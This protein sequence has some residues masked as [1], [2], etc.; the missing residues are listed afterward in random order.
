M[1]RYNW[2]DIYTKKNFE[3][4]LSIFKGIPDIKFLEIGSFE[5]KA[6]IWLLENILTHSSAK[7]T[8]I[9][10]FEGSSEHKFRCIN[11][12]NLYDIFV[13]NTDIHKKKISVLIGKSQELLRREDMMSPIFNFI[14][15]D[16]SHRAS[17]VLEDAIL[18][19]RL[20]K[21]GGIIIF[22]D[23]QWKFPGRKEYDI[24]SPRIA[25]DAFLS[26]FKEQYTLLSKEYQVVIEKL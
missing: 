1:F 19:F 18:S 22:D 14:Y 13:K 17:D 10:T 5:G 20:L 6:T 21:K 4:Y 12:K 15:I 24:D 8:C 16:G 7:I 9:D 3:K 25:I 26:I 11:T 2:F 23:Y